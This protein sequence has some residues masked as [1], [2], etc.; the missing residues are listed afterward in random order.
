MTTVKAN[1]QKFAARAEAAIT[2]PVVCIPEF[3]FCIY[4]SKEEA[5]ITLKDTRNSPSIKLYGIFSRDHPRRVS[6]SADQF[7]VSP[8]HYGEECNS[9]AY[10]YASPSEVM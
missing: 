6:S 9:K 2:T 10:L 4:K 5:E 3:E 8:S 7:C 1:H